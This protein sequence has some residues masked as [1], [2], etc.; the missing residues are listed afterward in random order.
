MDKDAYYFYNKVSDTLVITFLKN[1]EFVSYEVDENVFLR[2]ADSLKH[3]ELNHELVGIEI[4][5][6]RFKK[7]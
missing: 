6:F 4:K 7:D 3:P 1:I 2:R 5:N